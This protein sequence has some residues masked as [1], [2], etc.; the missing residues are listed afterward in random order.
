MQCALDQ[1]SITNSHMHLAHEHTVN[2]TYV[3]L[4]KT[5][6]EIDEKEDKQN[7]RA[8]LLQRLAFVLL[9]TDLRPCCPHSP[10][11][12][13]TAFYLRLNVNVKINKTSHR[14]NIHKLL[15]PFYMLFMD[16]GWNATSVR[17]YTWK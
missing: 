3:Y 14:V 12:H 2:M 4:I 9:A 10:E 5:D 17:Y 16:K 8:C 1:G 11:A 6:T 15:K 13:D 7:L